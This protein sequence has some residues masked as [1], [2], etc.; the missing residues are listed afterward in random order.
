M[1][2]VNVTYPQAS[3]VPKTAS[4]D[5]KTV[6]NDDQ[7]EFLGTSIQIFLGRIWAKILVY[8]MSN[9]DA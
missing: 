9:I 8:L 4:N 7:I 2:T 6:S 5:D 1:T 3:K